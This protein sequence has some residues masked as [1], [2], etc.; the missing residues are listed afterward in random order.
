MATKK[1]SETVEAFVLRDCVV[2]EVGTVVVL[3]AADA[4][5]G[6]AQGMLDLN[7]GAIKAAKQE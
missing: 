1:T 4:E 6:A 7:P 5:T 3:S 2:G